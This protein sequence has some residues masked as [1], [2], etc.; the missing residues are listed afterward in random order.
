[1]VGMPPPSHPFCGRRFPNCTWPPSAAA[2][3][4]DDE[5][6][7]LPP[8]TACAGSFVSLLT[9]EAY[10]SAAL[11]LH[12]QFQRVHTRCPFT[13]VYDDAAI[14]ESSSKRLALTF[15]TRLLRLSELVASVG[16]IVRKAREQPLI[17]KRARALAGRLTRPAAGNGPKSWGLQSLQKIWLWSLPPARYPLA[18]F[19]DLD[20][21][22]RE[23][24]DALLDPRVLDHE[25]VA[26]TE[27]FSLAAVSALGCRTG[28]NVFNAALLVF[29]PSRTTLSALLRRDRSFERVGQACEVSLTDQSL[30]N[31][32]YRGS[33]VPQRAGSTLCKGVRWRRLPLSYNVNA[34]QLANIPTRY[35]R[36]V[37]VA[38]VHFAGGWSKPWDVLPASAPPERRA[39]LRREGHVRDEWR[40][41]CNA[42]TTHSTL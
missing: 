31:A 7:L 3:I 10:T 42:T 8:S 5:W 41:A 40:H 19:V 32:E 33:C 11:C 39:A 6:Q 2:A 28:A 1:L 20:V 34:Q 17:N 26:G 38:L 21:L 16:A 12:A 36:G 13:L 22:I 35:W 9:S 15:G 25:G 24:L 29:R 23:N 27:S 30:L 14:G 4:D 37:N 18:C